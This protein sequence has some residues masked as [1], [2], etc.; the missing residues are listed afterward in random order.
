MYVGRC[1]YVQYI[2]CVNIKQV[3]VNQIRVLVSV[4][5]VSVKY[6][7]NMSVCK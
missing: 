6:I 7:S 2:V 1:V 5:Y 3:C 4:K